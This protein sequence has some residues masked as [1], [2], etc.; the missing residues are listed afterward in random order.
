[1][2]AGSAVVS[3]GGGG[4]RQAKPRARET[5]HKALGFCLLFEGCH[6][7]TGTAAEQDGTTGQERAHLPQ[8]EVIIVRELHGDPLDRVLR[9]VFSV[10]RR[11][12][13]GARM[14]SAQVTGGATT[15]RFA[16]IA[17]H[18]HHRRLGHAEGGVSQVPRGVVLRVSR[19]FTVATALPRSP[20]TALSAALGRRSPYCFW[21][22]SNAAKTSM[23]KNPF[24]YT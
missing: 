8:E 24:I 23:N 13:A 16:P 22:L 11:R 6:Q 10:S 18:A 5:D 7:R 9:E 15:T 21:I 17:V 12:K 14:P 2:P 20:L 19:W 1:M 3:G 4:W